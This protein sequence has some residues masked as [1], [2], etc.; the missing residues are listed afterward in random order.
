MYWTLFAGNSTFIFLYRN[1]SRERKKK[2]R[3][4]EKTWTVKMVYF[5]VTLASFPTNCGVEWDDDIDFWRETRL[6]FR[7]W[8]PSQELRP[9]PRKISPLPSCW[10]ARNFSK[11]YDLYISSYYLHIFHIFLHISFIFLNFSFIFL[12]Y[13]FI[14]PEALEL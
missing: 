8:E 5:R 6:P 12:P 2:A 13:S 4:I 1:F 10:K 9:H 3:K 7:Y 11:S 14:F